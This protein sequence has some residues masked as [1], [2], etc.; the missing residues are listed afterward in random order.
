[1]RWDASGLDPF[2]PGR[3]LVLTTC[4]PLD[5]KTA[6]PLRYLVHAELIADTASAE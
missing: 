5:A 6:G 1:V 3:N 2:A 4:W